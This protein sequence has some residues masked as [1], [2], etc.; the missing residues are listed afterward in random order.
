MGIKPIKKKNNNA[1]P[2]IKIKAKNTDSK[3]T[4]QSKNGVL[5]V[6]PVKM[7]HLM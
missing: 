5:K 2:Q 1:S 7:F 3:D 6:F 4:N